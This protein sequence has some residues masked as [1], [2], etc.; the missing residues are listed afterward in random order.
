MNIAHYGA[1]IKLHLGD[2]QR[3]V[4]ERLLAE[5]EEAL[6]TDLEKQQ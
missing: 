6:A 3:S 2:E 5:A 1:M 4:L